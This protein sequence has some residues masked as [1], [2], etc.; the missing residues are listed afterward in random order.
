MSPDGVILLLAP[1]IDKKS[2]SEKFI[3]L[4]FPGEVTVGSSRIHVLW[5][6]SW[7]H[8]YSP[9]TKALRRPK[10]LNIN[11]VLS[12]QGWPLVVLVL[13]DILKHVQPHLNH[14]KKSLFVDLKVYNPPARST[15][16][17]EARKPTHITCRSQQPS[18]QTAMLQ[19]HITYNSCHGQA[20]ICDSQA[21]P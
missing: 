12:I 19:N 13:D 4:L 14:S 16:L 21:A 8:A 9:F 10:M 7:F 2:G 18:V 1:I 6:Q 15:T 5:S 11:M 3:Y 20:V 17:H